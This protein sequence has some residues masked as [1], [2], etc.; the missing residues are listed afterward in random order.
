[1]ELKK[2]LVAAIA[3]ICLFAAGAARWQWP[4]QEALQGSLLRLGIVFGALWLALP[5]PGTSPRIERGAG[6]ILAAF[7]LLV[8]L[9]RSLLAV[10]PFLALL[11]VLIW[12]FG[13]RRPR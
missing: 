4:E 6:V 7:F 5:K 8:F 10:L 11:G 2:P 3:V 12:V 1:M 9:R 13:P